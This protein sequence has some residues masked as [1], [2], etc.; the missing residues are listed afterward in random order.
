MGWENE[1]EEP[2][3]ELHYRSVRRNRARD[4]E[5]ASCLMES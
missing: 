1:E 2:K 4:P 5:I 3:V